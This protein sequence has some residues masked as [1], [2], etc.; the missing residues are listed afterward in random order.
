MSVDKWTADYLPEWQ[1]AG[2]N[3]WQYNV[4]N[5]CG[6]NTPL[7]V[8]SP[9]DDPEDL[10]SEDEEMETFASCVPFLVVFGN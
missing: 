4:T 7:T 9:F 3:D 8:L 10:G 5:S 1:G 2:A 6:T